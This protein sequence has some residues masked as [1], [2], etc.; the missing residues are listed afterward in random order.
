MIEPTAHKSDTG[1]TTMI[2]A[3]IPELSGML[4]PSGFSSINHNY[5]SSF[6]TPG[7]DTTALEKRTLEAVSLSGIDADVE[8]VTDYAAIAAH[9]VLAGRVPKAWELQSLLSRA[10]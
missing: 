10:R 9:V 7:N 6:D 3:L 2:E 1:K 8:K 5:L 4:S